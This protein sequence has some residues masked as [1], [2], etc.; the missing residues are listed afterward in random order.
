MVTYHVKIS[1]NDITGTGTESN[2]WRTIT[3]GLS[4]CAA[5]GAAFDSSADELLVWYDA[6]TPYAESVVFPGGG[7]TGLVA[8]G[9]DSAGVRADAAG[10]NRDEMVVV[11]PVAAVGVQFDDWSHMRGFE[12]DG[13]NAGANNG[14]D[15]LGGARI[16]WLED[17]E[18][19]GFNGLGWTNHGNGSESDRLEVND[20][21]GGIGIDA[22]VAT[23]VSIRTTL[24]TGC[25][26][27][28][29][30]QVIGANA[31]VEH[32][33]VT[34]CGTVGGY[35]IYAPGAGTFVRNCIV[36]DNL[37]AYGIRTSGAVNVV[38]C[39]AYTSNPATFHT[40]ANFFHLPQDGQ[41]HEAAPELDVNQRP[42]VTSPC[43]EAGS[44]AAT[45]V[46]DLSGVAFR[47]LPSMGALEFL[48]IPDPGSGDE[49]QVRWSA[50]ATGDPVRPDAAY[51]PF[52]LDRDALRSAVLASWFCDARAD[53]DDEVPDGRSRRGWWADT[54][55]GDN[56]GSRLWLLHRAPVTDET[57]ARVEQYLSEALD[58]MLT[59]NVA[60]DFEV[61]AERTGTYRISATVTID[62]D[63]REQVTLEFSDLWRD[64]YA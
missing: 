29:G 10:W 31:V 28:R 37:T 42:L 53:S 34:G 61:T 23:G 63:E 35:G 7:K 3:F 39:C 22:G 11:Q 44:T 20:C 25:A 26:G 36:A 57:V 18:I 62:R 64:L 30:I 40:A 47:P 51:E 52:Q 43:R 32:C 12:F 21:T 33:T 27:T 4:Q 38:N 48:G 54:Q 2:P 17:C 56:F 8:Y 55:T 1:G 14:A 15:T 6:T 41:S 24:V 5:G 60:T 16:S 45:S 13:V 46:Y 19:Q 49:Q 9:V 58:W 50:I 59:R